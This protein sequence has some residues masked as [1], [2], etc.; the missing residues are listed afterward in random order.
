MA[1]T[2][3]QSPPSPNYSGNDLVYVLSST[4]ITENTFSF[5]I[6]ITVG[7]DTF[8]YRKQPNPTSRGIINVSSIVNDNLDWE[9]ES[10][11]ASSDNVAVS[12]EKDFSIVFSEEFVQSSG[13]LGIVNPITATPIKI[14][15]GVSPQDTYITTDTVSIP[16]VISSFPNTGMR[17]LRTATLPITL[18]DGTEITQSNITIPGSGD[19]VTFTQGTSGT[20]T[21]EIYDTPSDLGELTFYWFNKIGGIDWFTFDQAGT[22]S[23][24]VSK[25]TSPA[26]SINHG[27][28]TALNR[29]SR[30][31]NVWKSQQNTYRIDFDETHT[32]NSRWLSQEMSDYVGGLFESPEVFIK[33]GTLF[34]P[35]EILNSS[36]D[37]QTA[38]REVELFNYE[39]MYRYTNN[40]RSL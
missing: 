35:V 18:W 5:V 37:A 14:I 31:A 28:T 21:F 13:S 38:R 23:T 27:F 33:H 25:E 22:T 1:I 8:R 34:R 11:G 30:N 12:Q 6:D 26:S 17:V 7:S 40:K 4:N 2:I 39:V 32:K 3:N 19:T 15:K 9:V 29:D 20:Y 16:P 36:Y 24:S 10:L